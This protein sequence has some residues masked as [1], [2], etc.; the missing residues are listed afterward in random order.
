MYQI[1]NQNIKTT[2]KKKKKMSW[3][4]LRV[5]KKHLKENFKINKKYSKI[6]TKNLTIYFF[7]N[8]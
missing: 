7:N 3:I 8:F 5:Y 2:D 1:K 6:K 4:S